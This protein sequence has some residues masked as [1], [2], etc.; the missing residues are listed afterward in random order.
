[1]ENC[2]LCGMKASIDLPDW[3]GG[4]FSIDC[5][6]CGQYSTNQ[7]V[8]TEIERLKAEHSPRID[9]LRYTIDI[10]DHRWYLNWSQSLNSIVFELE[11]PQ[12]LSKRDKKGLS[13]H[14]RQN[15]PSPVGKVFRIDSEEN[16]DGRDD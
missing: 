14:Y 12:E 10:A 1:M 15:Q 3:S 8:I 16:D 6:N 2:P 9:E 7:I 4:R 5:A 11:T 13:K